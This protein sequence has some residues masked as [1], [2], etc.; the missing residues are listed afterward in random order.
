MPT[1]GLLHLLTSTTASTPSRANMRIPYAVL[2]A[3]P[4]VWFVGNGVPS[5]AMTLPYSAR[6]TVAVKQ[7]ITALW[8]P[9]P[10]Y[11]SF[12]LLGAHLL[13]GG[14][15]TAGDAPTP[16]GR[17]ASASALR[18]I[19]GTLFG[20]A[21]VPHVVAVTVSAATVF[22]PKIF[23]P[24]YVAAL[25]PAV[26]L[27]AVLPWSPSP[28]AQIKTLGD[29]VHAFLGWDYKITAASVLLWTSVLHARA[30]KYYEGK[31]VSLL[32]FLGKLVMLVAMAGPGAAAVQLMWEREELI[33]Q[34]EDKQLASKKRS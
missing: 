26:V 32:P 27:D 34:S 8:Q 3:F 23:S 19:Y 11:T 5:L 22:A 12:G 29:G 9:W 10:A 1:Y 6:N 28:I 25:H 16:A 18:W 15:F 7:L 4:A 24:T 17:K 30:H 21:A 33:L 2:L 31:C 14:I 20:L 13:L